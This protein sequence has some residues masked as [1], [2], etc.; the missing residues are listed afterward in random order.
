MLAFSEMRA[1][2]VARTVKMS[3]GVGRPAGG[4]MTGFDGRQ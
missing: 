1:S 2:S 4:E 3:A